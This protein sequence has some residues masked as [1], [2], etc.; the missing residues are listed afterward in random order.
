MN[1]R[2][3][4]LKTAALFERHPQA[5]DF[6]MINVPSGYPGPE[7]G[8]VGCVLG[9][10]GH[11]LN[12]FGRYATYSRVAAGIGLE[13]EPYFDRAGFPTE[14]VSSGAFA[15]YTFYNRM[16]ALA[17]D[18][19]WMVHPSEAARVLRLYADAYHPNQL[20]EAA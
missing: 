6:T 8:S 18:N 13:P 7:C 12:C 15:E 2:D 9:W 4:F 11:F 16:N 14:C 3:A 20:Q 19:R 1:L 5:Y 10:V 17:G